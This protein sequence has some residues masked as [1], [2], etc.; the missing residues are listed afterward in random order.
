MLKS[1]GVQEEM[2]AGSLASLEWAGG[3]SGE[4]WVLHCAAIDGAYWPADNRWVSWLKK[5]LSNNLV[6]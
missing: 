1:T 4:E 2:G 5:V 3:H 6:L